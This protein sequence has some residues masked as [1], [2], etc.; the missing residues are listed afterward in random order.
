MRWISTVC[1]HLFLIFESY[2]ISFP[3]QSVQCC[4]I[5]IEFPINLFFLFPDR[6]SG[7]PGWPQ[8][9][10]IVKYD[11]GLL[12]HL[13]ILRLQTWAMPGL[14]DGSQ[15]F[16]HARQACHQLSSA[17]LVEFEESFVQLNTQCSGGCRNLVRLKCRKCWRQNFLEGKLVVPMYWEIYVFILN[18][19]CKQGLAYCTAMSSM[20]IA[21]WVGWSHTHRDHPASKRCSE[22]A[23]TRSSVLFSSWIHLCVW[24]LYLHVCM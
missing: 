12:I 2:L 6:G 7:S 20:E 21:M 24:V 19:F 16:K 18:Y 11:L 9:H 8:T 5:S 10:R 13:L 22:G 15:G 17:P 3:C 23:C 1:P 4:Y 14:G